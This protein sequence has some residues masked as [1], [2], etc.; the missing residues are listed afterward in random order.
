MNRIR[1]D[2]L[3]PLRRLWENP[4]WSFAAVYL[5]VFSVNF[6]SDMIQGS[7]LARA[8][9]HGWVGMK[10]FW[11]SPTIQIWLVFFMVFLIVWSVHQTRA[12]LKETNSVELA[13]ASEAAA[14]QTRV[15]EEV[16]GSFAQLAI[17]AEAAVLGFEAAIKIQQIIEGRTSSRVLMYLAFFQEGLPRTDQMDLARVSAAT[18]EAQTMLPLFNRLLL[19]VGI[20]PLDMPGFPEPQPTDNPD[21][22]SPRIVQGQ[23]NRE[24]FNAHG[25]LTAQV[26]DRL[27]RLE[28]HLQELRQQQ[29]AAKAKLL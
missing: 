4:A 2:I 1:E 8:L 14:Q 19:A 22:R 28:R 18:A 16:R 23:F 27:E 21:G 26:R 11:S 29:D 3:K 17:R 24:L 7:S 5:A 12:V 13:R 25:N 15:L 9:V 6:V 10:A 20:P